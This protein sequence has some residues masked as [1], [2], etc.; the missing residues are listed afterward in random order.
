MPKRKPEILVNPENLTRGELARVMR[1]DVRTISRWLKDGLPRNPETGRFVLSEVI[2][3]RLDR[4]DR[5]MIGDADAKTN[6]TESG[7]ASPWLE[8]YRR[9]RALMA[10]Y[11]RKQLQKVLVS[12]KSLDELLNKLFAD[13]R[14][15]MLS[16]PNRI[17]P[18][19]TDNRIKLK[20]ETQRLL[21]QFKK[22]KSFAI[23]ES[24]EDTSS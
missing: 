17:F 14:G 22:A 19:D 15:T 9:E 4:T 10:A 3:W 7:G 6:S 16:W 20:E 11:E 24:D 1:F 12:R 5:A 21:E 18:N 8:R 2:T 23:Q 13:I